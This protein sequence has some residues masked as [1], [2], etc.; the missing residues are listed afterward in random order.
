MPFSYKDFIRRQKGPN[1]LDFLYKYLDFLF[2]TGSFVGIPVEEDSM[3]KKPLLGSSRAG[4]RNKRHRIVLFRRLCPAV[5]DRL[6]GDGSDILPV[7]L[8]RVASP[9]AFAVRTV[10]I[11]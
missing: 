10:H 4:A 11:I 2:Y 3:Y 8:E 6:F 7:F 9:I 1:F 5:I